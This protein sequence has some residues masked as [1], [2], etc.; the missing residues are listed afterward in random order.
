MALVELNGRIEEIRKEPPKCAVMIDIWSRSTTALPDR[1]TGGIV[2][3]L[4]R[5]VVYPIS[6]DYVGGGTDP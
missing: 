2:V 6:I 4:G 3:C 1:D 5:D